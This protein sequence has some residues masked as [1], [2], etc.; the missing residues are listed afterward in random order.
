MTKNL[1]RDIYSGYFGFGFILLMLAISVFRLIAKH[2]FTSPI[3]LLMHEVNSMHIPISALNTG[4]TNIV[5]TAFI[6]KTIA[7]VFIC[8]SL[9]L[10]CRYF[11]RGDFFIPANVRYFKIASWSAFAYICGQFIEGMA[12]NW[13]SATE[14]IEH[15]ALPNGVDD[16]TFIPLYILFMVLSMTSI[17]ITRAVKLQ[18]DQEGLI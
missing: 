5:L 6:I 16:P 9:L 17:A 4:Q 14:G 10:A 11:L 13:V 2:T 1:R 18:E 7:T 15:N 12:N 3:G 8:I